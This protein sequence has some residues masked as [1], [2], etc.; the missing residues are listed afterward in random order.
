[1]NI[2]KGYRFIYQVLK[3][4]KYN[5]T[6]TVVHEVEWT[7]SSSSIPI[8][9]GPRRAESHAPAITLD[10]RAPISGGRLWPKSPNLGVE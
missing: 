5:Q 6:T 9:Y 10:S 2:L 4:E 7:F 1:L 8:P 3:F